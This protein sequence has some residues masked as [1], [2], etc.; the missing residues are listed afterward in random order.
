VSLNQTSP[1]SYEPITLEEA[2]RHLRVTHNDDDTLIG[3][4]IAA[5]RDKA[6]TIQDRQLVTATWVLKMDAFP[7][8]DEIRVPLPPLQSVTS[9]TY[10]DTDG[11]SQTMSSGDYDVDTASEPGRIAL[12]YG[13]SWPST[14][15][16]IDAVTVTYVA[17]YADQQQETRITPL[18]VEVGDVFNILIDG[19]V[20]ATYTAAAATVA[21]VTA[22]LVAAM[23]VSGITDSDE[24]TH[25]KLLGT[26][27]VPFEVTV[28][29]TDAGG[30][31][32]QALSVTTVT[33]AS[34]VPESTRAGIL[35]IV[36]HL[37]E[38]REDSIVG[39]SVAMLPKGSYDLLAL[40]AVPELV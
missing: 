28:T 1:P 20:V 40:N 11:V 24:T 3:A 26:S 2:K 31:D 25:V 6:Q 13:A 10:T 38:N 33:R 21:D 19:V 34:G 32:T 22:G 36:G 8:G 17:G 18:A 9:I 15:T 35:L 30:T 12:S 16:E 4:L 37:Y 23:N 5:A 27:G 14:R 7:S 39:V 29:T